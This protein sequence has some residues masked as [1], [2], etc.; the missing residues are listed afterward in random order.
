MVAEEV[1]KLAEQSQEAA[2]KI[3]T[4]IG[5]IQG[6]TAKAVVAM[7]DGT[8]EVRLGAEVVNESGQVF[9]EIAAMITFGSDQM[10][11]ISVA[12]E[13]MAVGGQQIV[14][15]VNRI[16]ELSKKASGEAQTVSAATEEQSASMEEI[17]SA[18]QALAHLA[19]KLREAVS[20]F[21]I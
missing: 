21:Q 15:S 3:A 7:N 1:R 4:L 20:Q 18:S 5:E 8:R 17:A 14:S 6:D 11:E 10:K 9:Q 19:M 13:Q 16:D 2:Q 12:V